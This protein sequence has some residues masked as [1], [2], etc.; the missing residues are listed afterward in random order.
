MASFFLREPDLLLLFF[1][2]ILLAGKVPFVLI[3]MLIVLGEHARSLLASLEAPPAFCSLA[4][5]VTLCVLEAVIRIRSR[6]ELQ[7]LVV[8]FLRDCLGSTSMPG[9]HVPSLILAY[10][11]P[12]LNLLRFLFN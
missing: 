1:F 6:L 12:A 10:L 2:T 3:S 7:Y 8:V 9:N 5:L 11:G 4:F